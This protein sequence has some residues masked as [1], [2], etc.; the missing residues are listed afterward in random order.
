MSEPAFTLGDRQALIA[1]HPL[2]CHDPQAWLHNGFALLQTCS[3]PG[4]Q[5]A[6]PTQNCQHRPAPPSGPLG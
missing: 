1:A 4:Y 2:E 3:Q 5:F 6:G